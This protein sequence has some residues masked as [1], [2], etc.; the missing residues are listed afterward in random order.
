[1][2]TSGTIGGSANSYFCSDCTATTE[3]S[4]D[5][6]DGNFYCINGG[7]VKNFAPACTC[8]DCNLGFGGPSCAVC[9]DG[10][11]GDDC[12]PGGCTATTNPTDD[13]MDGNFYCINGGTV[14]GAAASC[15]CTCAAG[16]FGPSCDS[17]IT[18]TLSGSSTGNCAVDG[19]CFSSLDYTSNERCDFSVAVGGVLN[20]VS[21]ETESG[22][23]KMTI[24]GVI[25]M[26]SDGPA[27]VVISAGETITW[28]SDSSVTRAG[29]EICIGN[30]C[31]ATTTPSDDGST[32]D[33]YCINGGAVEGFS[34]SCTCTGCDAGYGGANCATCPDGYSG[35]PPGSCAGAACSATST[36]TDDG[37]NGNFYCVNGGSI[38]GITGS[39][40]CTCLTG[41]NGASCENAAPCVATSTPT[42]DG[43]EG[44]YYCINGGFAAGTTGDCSCDCAMGFAG[45]A[46]D[47]CAPGFSGGKNCF[48]AGRSRRRKDLYSSTN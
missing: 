43:T 16:W 48:D 24:G 47:I 10:F 27:D 40:T 44:D 9:A 29:Y 34:G 26:G 15:V 36:S 1:M 38:G 46:C 45:D 12:T 25:Y 17:D 4:D 2:A 35:T 8:T 14:S 39:C 20:I 42:D 32:G 6:T 21:F 7:S 13:G 37:A 19:S 33:F 11:S 3:P 18:I 31:V 41:F 30:P 22:Y 5:G 28:Y 23:D